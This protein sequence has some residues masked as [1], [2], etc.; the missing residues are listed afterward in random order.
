MPRVPSQS[1]LL[2]AGLG[3]LLIVVVLAVL[4]H[5]SRRRSVHVPLVA[6]VAVAASGF[7]NLASTLNPSDDGRL[8]LLRETVGAGVPDMARALAVPVGITLLLA[9][10]YLARR[11]RRA[12]DVAVGSLAILAV[13]NVVKGLDVATGI[14]TGGVAL[15]LWGARGAFDVEPLQERWTSTIGTIARMAVGVLAATVAALALVTWRD[16]GD[17]SFGTIVHESLALL[18]LARD[19]TLPMPHHMGW[20]PGAIGVTGLMTLLLALVLLFRR[21]PVDADYGARERAGAVIARHGT[22]TLSGF[23]R[24]TD[25]IPH[26]TAD[27]RAAG[28]FSIRAGVLFVGGAP[29]GPDDAVDEL[30]DELRGIADHHDVRMAVL[31]AG[32]ELADRVCGRTRMKAMYIGDEAMIDVASF[33][34]KGRPLKKVR[35]AVGRVEREGYTSEVVRIGD[36]DT[37]TRADVAAVITAWGEKEAHGFC[38]EMP[39]ADAAS[40]DSL[41]VLARD[42][43][44]RVRALIHVVPSPAGGNWSLSSTPHERGL[45]NGV[46]DFL[47]VK[48]I[49]EAKARGMERVSLN[50]AAYRQWIHEPRTRWERTMG[51]VVKFLDR[52]FQIERL[53]RFNKKFD[54]AWVPRYMLYDGRTAQLRT[55]W[56][57]MLVEGQI[58]LPSVPF[59]R[60]LS[61]RPARRA[62]GP[63]RAPRG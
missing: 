4:A 27:G 25:V 8:E 1:H 32:Q 36:M 6:G 49:E 45:P 47:V 13:L 11:H 48:M 52:Y 43:D 46:V 10:R 58:R 34:T 29:S 14:A 57:A 24:R 2:T 63:A 3:L 60:A 37:A 17:A 51:P 9:G 40:A 53:Y 33:T 31:C 23:A 44:G 30:L 56:A 41:A 5:L 7:A 42:A 19:T 21:P 16:G 39:L 61:L 26:V 55:M 38:M 54:P 35:Q 62:I 50:F 15:V 59:P 22:D 18:T 12:L 20:L 28:T